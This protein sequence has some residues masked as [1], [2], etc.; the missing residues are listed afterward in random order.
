MSNS[1]VGGEGKLRHF[2]GLLTG[3]DA[4]GQFIWEIINHPE[5]IIK[6]LSSYQ[7]RLAS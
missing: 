2:R 5:F 6:E 1:H 3:L 4:S 7:T